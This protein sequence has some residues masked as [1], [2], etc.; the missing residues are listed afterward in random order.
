MNAREHRNTDGELLTVSQT[1]ENANL[2]VAMVRRIAEEAGAVRRIGRLYRIDR[3]I[4]FDFIAK[5]YSR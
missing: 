4:F 2:G 3:A 1:A 5:K